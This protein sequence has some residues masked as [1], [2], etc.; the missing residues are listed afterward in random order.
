ME[1]FNKDPNIMLPG[2]NPL[3]QVNIWRQVMRSIYLWHMAA[4]LFFWCSSI[5]YMEER[6]SWRYL[7][8]QEDS[9]HCAYGHWTELALLYQLTH[10]LCMEC[11]L[12]EQETCKD[13]LTCPLIEVRLILQHGLGL[14]LRQPQS[15]QVQVGNCDRKIF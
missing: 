15:L 11:L 6:M 1:C 4:D 8:H 10:A 2:L 13:F 9:R 3:S 5:E 14:V 12:R 7:Y